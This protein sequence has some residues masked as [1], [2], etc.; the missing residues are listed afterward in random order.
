VVV[1]VAN[2]VELSVG[3]TEA[4]GVHKK[5]GVGLLSLKV[6]LQFRSEPLPGF[7]L[8]STTCSVQMPLT[9]QADKL[10]NGCS[11]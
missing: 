2:A 4:D 6:I 3:F 7:T 11:E 9:A 1:G 8:S 5:S 10:L